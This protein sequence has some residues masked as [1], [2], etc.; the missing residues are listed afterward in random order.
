[1]KQIQ[2]TQNQYAMVND[3]DFEELSKHRWYAL[4]LCYGGF[5]A[6]RND[7]ID[8]KKGKREIILMPRQIMNAPEGMDI[9]HQNHDT[10]DNRKENLRICTRSQNLAN[11]GKQRNCSSKFKGVSWNKD[12]T[13]WRVQIQKDGKQHYLASCDSEIEAAKVYDEAAIK[14]FGEFAYLNF[15]RK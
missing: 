7:P 6:G 10:L 8:E 13:N 15:R 5:A 2:L 14:H 11:R 3:E 12:N 9:D 1:M 4:K